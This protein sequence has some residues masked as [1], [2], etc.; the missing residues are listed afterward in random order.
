MTEPGREALVRTEK[1]EHSDSRER[2]KALVLDGVTSEHSKRAYGKALDA[3]EGWVRETGA[4]GFTKATVQAWRAALDEAG[5]AP[6]SINV[7]LS[8]IRKLAAEAAANGLLAPDVAAAIGRVKG[9]KRAGMRAGNWL[10][11]DA[12]E[13]LLELPDRST[14][15]G[16]R[17]RALLALLLGCGLRR[18]ELAKLRIE[19]IQQRDGRWCVVDILGKGNRVRTVPM[20]AWAKAA[21]DE[22]LAA[23]GYQSG[24]VLGCVNKGDRITGQ[25]M[26]AQSIYKVVEGYGAKLGTALAPH[27]LRRTFAKL[28][29]KGRAPIEQIQISLGHASV[30]TTERYLGVQ[31]DLTDAPCD[32]LGIR[33]G[34]N[35][36]CA[37][38]RA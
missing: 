15:K 22:W 26:N 13:R 28:A 35:R 19:E 33:A 38:E 11:L 30:Q 24:P 34:G 16:L 31:Q 32:Y 3:F 6:S 12:A 25:G 36:P 17:D 9:A 14:R 2:I 27:D 1:R 20:P 4:D 8:A 7:R 29:H 5:L 18:E 23:T 21:I 10:T 37:R